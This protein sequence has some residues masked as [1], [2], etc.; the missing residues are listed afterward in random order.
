MKIEKLRGTNLN[1]FFSLK[2]KI[3]TDLKGRPFLRNVLLLAGGTALA[4]IIMIATSPIISRLFSPEDMGVLSVYTSILGMIAAFATLRFEL[5]I[6][7]ADND[8][9]AINV[10]SLSL[11]SVAV[12]SIVVLVFTTTF[13]NSITTI[14]NAQSLKPFLWLLSVGTIGIG[15]Y[16]TF[17]HWTMRKRAYKDITRTKVNQGIAKVA[18]QIT[19]G[20]VGLGPIGLILGE[21]LGQAFGIRALSKSLLHEEMRVWREINIRS[22]KSM[23][24]RYKK[25]PLVSSWSAL[26]NTAGFSLPVLLLSSLYGAEVAGS[27]GFSQ[28]IV[29]I[30]LN[31]IGVAISQ[32]FFSE[33]AT[34]SKEDPQKL[35]KLTVSTAKKLF[36]MGLLI[37]AILILFGPWLFAFVFG[38]TW[39]EA[40]VYSQVLSIMLVTR[41]AVSP[42]SHALLILEKQGTQFLL[43]LLRL[44]LIIIALFASKMLELSPVEAIVAYA[45]SMVIVYSITYFAIIRALRQN[46]RVRNNKPT[47]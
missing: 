35:L 4:Q 18:V 15:V 19:S 42:I 27:F 1:S 46:A 20:F 5:A 47:S 8:E 17:L 3:L 44:V 45:I 21:I 22:M 38:D 23:A 39:R 28:R 26:L 6:P 34:L 41:F 9:S 29:S 10:L 2:N 12:V 25:F 32:V 7:I 14:L 37:A 31:L 33:G 11:I 40:G 16:T 30:P 24:S 36:L 13:A 43:D